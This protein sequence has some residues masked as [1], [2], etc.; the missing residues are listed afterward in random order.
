[1]APISQPT[2]AHKAVAAMLGAARAGATTGDV[3]VAAVA[4]LSPAEAHAA[5][6]YG[7]GG[8]IGLAH[9]EGMPIRIGGTERLVASSVLALRAHVAAGPNPSI[10]AAVASV[11]ASGATRLQSLRIAG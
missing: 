5:L 2:A 11:A 10:D 6:E 8:T 9:D 7:L 4:A 1:M 3:A